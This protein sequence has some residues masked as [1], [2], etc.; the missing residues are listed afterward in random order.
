MEDSSEQKKNIEIS[1]LK[2]DKLFNENTPFI[3]NLFAPEVKEQE[4]KRVSADLICV[5]DISGSMQGE[6]IEQVKESLNILV[7]MMDPKDRIALVLF[8]QQAKLLYDLN[9]LDTKNKEQ[10]KNLIKS[11][12]ARGGTNIASGL[13]IAVDILKKEKKNVKDNESRSSS[14]ILLSDGCDNYSN[15][16]VLAEKLKSFTKGEGLSFTLNTFGYGYDHDPKIM[17][18]LANLRDGS[19]FL[20][21]DYNKVG[22]YFVSV[23]G[24]CISMISKKAE[25]EVKLLNEKCKIVKIFGENNF[26]SYDLNDLFF[27]NKMLQFITGKEYTFVLEIF[28]DESA[29]KPGDVLIEVKFIYE[30]ILSKQEIKLNTLYKYELKDLKFAKANEEYIRS[31]TYDVLEKVLKLNEENKTEEA[32]KLLNEMKD[33]LEKNY[34]GENKSY[35]E[36]VKKSEQMFEYGFNARRGVTCTISMVS[37][38]ISKRMGSNNMYSNSIQNRL[39]DNYRKNYTSSQAANINKK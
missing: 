30:D 26:Y 17:N 23:L 6:K 25:V 34:K 24:G 19:F 18:K 15:D 13:E 38:N 37:Q 16:I 35:L 28:I 10:V 33:W 31:Q 14:I 12:E 7:D 3:I 21:E 4:E 20:V 27:K 22:E 9:Y 29:V 8:D 36:D 32:R 2:G 11:I 5:I 1:V 39:Q